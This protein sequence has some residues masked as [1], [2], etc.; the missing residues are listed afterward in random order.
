MPKVSVTAVAEARDPTAIDVIWSSPGERNVFSVYFV[1]ADGTMTS[2]I[3]RTG[4]GSAILH[5]WHGESY[6]FW[7]S[8]TTDLGWTDANSSTLVQLPAKIRGQVQ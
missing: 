8:V 1:Q 4:A 3:P 5:C 7:A 2:W 6:W